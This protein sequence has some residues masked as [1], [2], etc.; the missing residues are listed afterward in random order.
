MGSDVDLVY[1]G[2]NIFPWSL[3]L[4]PGAERWRKV[5]AK[6]GGRLQ[7]QLGEALGP[8]GGRFKPWSTEAKRGAPGTKNREKSRV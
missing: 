5:A 3:S 6:S 8:L 2:H 4:E 1:K 7:M